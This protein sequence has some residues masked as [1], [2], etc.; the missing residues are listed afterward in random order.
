MTRFRLFLAFIV[1]MIFSIAG[2]KVKNGITS[3]QAD[4]K[5]EAM[6]AWFLGY[7]SSNASGSGAAWSPV[8]A[9]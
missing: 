8:A 4:R 6:D 7:F 2:S 3:C 9:P 1:Q 5:A